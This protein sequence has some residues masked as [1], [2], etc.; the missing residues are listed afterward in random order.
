MRRKRVQRDARKRVIAHNVPEKGQSS[1]VPVSTG[2]LFYFI[3]S[4]KKCMG[5]SR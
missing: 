4:A 3:V 5:V 1:N 2:L